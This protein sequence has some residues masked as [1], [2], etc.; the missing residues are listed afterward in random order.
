MVV[1]GSLKNE[2]VVMKKARISSQV[3]LHSNPSLLLIYEL[4]I[5]L[6]LGASIS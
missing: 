6:L 5:A 3:D 2:S 4:Q 1:V